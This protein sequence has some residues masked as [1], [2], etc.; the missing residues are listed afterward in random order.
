MLLLDQ[1][2]TGRST[3]VTRHALARVPDQAAH[4]ALFRADSIVRDAEVVRRALLGDEP[5]TVLGQS[6]GGFCTLTYLSF[7]P[8]GL[9]EAF[10]TGG[11]PGVEEDADAAYRALCPIVEARNDDHYARHPDDVETV[12]RVVRHLRDHDVRLPGG[13]ALTVPAF[14]SLGHLL[15]GSAGSAA[16]HEVLEAPFTDDGELSDWFLQRV[17]RG[18][19]WS[20][21]FPLYAA[22]HEATYANGGG[23]TAW[24]AQRVL[25]E[26]PR[27][28]PDTAL[29]SG[30]PVLF[31]GEMV[32]PSVFDEDPLLRPSATPPTASP[33]APTGPPSTTPTGCAPTPSRSPPRCT[34]RTCTSAGS[35]RCAPPTSPAACASG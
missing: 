21:A 14:L 25:A 5:W 3:P 2:G 4:L 28:D 13:R 29:D 23:P 9:R 27:F 26:H 8:D 20:G 22:L 32:H 18:M 7:A 10:T 35:C 16:L 30:D 12:R 31:T 11:V 17:E 34:P 6:F 33:S 19:P 15:G 24:S 1:R